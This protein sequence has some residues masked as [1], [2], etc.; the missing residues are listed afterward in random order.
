MASFCS[1][2]NLSI[3]SYSI[4]ISYGFKGINLL[5]YKLGSLVN[6]LNRDKNGFSY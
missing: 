1:Y 2:S 4:I 6:F 5:R 3:N